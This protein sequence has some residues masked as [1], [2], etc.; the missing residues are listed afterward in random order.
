MSPEQYIQS[1]GS[2]FKGN[3]WS[4]RFDFISTPSYKDILDK[5]NSLSNKTVEKTA[6]F[7]FLQSKL[8]KLYSSNLSLSNPGDNNIPLSNY[9]GTPIGVSSP[10]WKGTLSAIT[11]PNDE[12]ELTD[13]IDKNQRT[14]KTRGK[15]PLNIT[16]FNDQWNINYTFWKMYISELSNGRIM[17]YHD[18]V[19]FDVF[20][21]LHS[22]NKGRNDSIIQQLCVKP[23]MTYRFSNCKVTNVSEL[24]LSYEGGSDKKTFTLTIDYF[25]KSTSFNIIA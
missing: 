8:A 23:S 22:I 20:I 7:L 12:V 14:T 5:R 19:S 4:Y 15:S 13:E 6:F 10:S 18:T 1:L 9:F 3:L 24:E 17:R 11:L 21:Y 2:G 25:D 16:I